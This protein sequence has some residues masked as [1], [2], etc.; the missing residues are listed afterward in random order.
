MVYLVFLLEKKNMPD[1][2]E[3]N[4]KVQKLFPSGNCYD[5]LDSS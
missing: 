2:M 5:F 3:K 4:V 1:I